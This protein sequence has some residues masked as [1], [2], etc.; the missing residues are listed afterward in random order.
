[1]GGEGGGMAPLVSL[2]MSHSLASRVGG[3]S[4]LLPL[5][6]NFFAEFIAEPRSALFWFNSVL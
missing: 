1:M 4:F 6:I 3:E 2:W 5:R